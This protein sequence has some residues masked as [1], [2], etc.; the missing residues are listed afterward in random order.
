[1]P[2]SEPAGCQSMGVMRLSKSDEGLNFHL[3]MMVKPI[4]MAPTQEAMT[5][6]TVSA[7]LGMEEE[8]A[9]ETVEAPLLAVAEASEVTV[10]VMK[11]TDLEVCEA[12]L[13]SAA[14]LLFEVSLG[15]GVV[16][17]FVGW[18]AVLVGVDELVGN[19][20]EEDCVDDAEEDEE[21]LEVELDDA[22][23]EEEDEAVELDEDDAEV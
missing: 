9:P 11:F 20:D 5:M 3:R 6:M 12:V 23:E 16:S 22:D 14:L 19:T 8:V 4:A 15:V 10:C 2:S 21:L 13:S 17:V 1:M 18:A 7:A